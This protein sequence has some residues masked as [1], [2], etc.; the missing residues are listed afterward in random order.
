M[1]NPKEIIANPDA[2]RQRLRHRMN[3]LTLIDRIID[4]HAKCKR[5]TAELDQKKQIRNRLSRQIAQGNVDVVDG[6]LESC[7]SFARELGNEINR[8]QTEL[9]DCQTQLDKLLAQIPNLPN[10]DVPDHPDETGNL[11][12]AQWGA[13]DRNIVDPKPHWDIGKPLGLDIERG[14]RIAGSR[15]YML[16]G[17]I[18]RLEFAIIQFMID[19]HTRQHG[20]ELVIPPYLANPDAMFGCGQLPKFKNELY[21]TQGSKYLIPTAESSIASMHAGEIL[22]TE[23][24]PRRYVA[25]SPCFRREAGAAGRDTRG[26]M[27]VHQFHKVELFK[28][29]APETSYQELDALVD[30]A[31]SILRMLALPYRKVLL[32]AG[33]MGFGAAKTFDLEVWLPSQGC[34]REI[35]SCS[36]VEAFQARRTN[37][38]FRRSANSKPEYVHMLNG[39]GLAV[40]RTMIAILENYQQADGSVVIP[41]ALRA[42]MGGLE[43]LSV[44]KMVVA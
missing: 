26:I 8:R 27:R 19:Q 15:F 2:I 24:L 35:S 37:T 17:E 4:L 39:S 36:N 3:D 14:T 7:K 20:Y 22:K 30:D 44:E 5:L 21:R 32:S 31:E 16:R 9:K 1:L 23:D 12:V 11:V 38:R 25:F 42:Y 33:D 28:F 40:G 18:A 29:T 43:L 41:E 34:Y 13:S 10:P 6:T